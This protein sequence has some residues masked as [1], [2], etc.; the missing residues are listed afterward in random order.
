MISPEYRAVAT[1]I[2]VLSPNGIG[3]NAFW[4]ASLMGIS[5]IKQLTFIDPDP[6]PSKIAGEIR[7]F[8]P[9]DYLDF[10]LVKRTGRAVHLGMAAT[11]LALEDAGMQ[12]DDIDKEN[13]ELIFG[14]GC[15]SIDSIG[16]TYETYLKQG[17]DRVHP[18]SLFAGSIHM[19][20]STICNELG[21]KSSS[22]TLSTRCTAGLNAIGYALQMIRTGRV[23]T[24]ITGGFDAPITGLLFAAFCKSGLL[25][26]FQG[27]P[28]KASRPFDRLRDG[29]VL[30]EGAA[31]FVMEE[32]EYAIRNKRRIYGE[33]VGFG[34][35]GEHF[36]NNHSS[37]NGKGPHEGMALAIDKA[38]MDA[39]MLPEKIDYISAHAPSDLVLDKMETD[40]IK[41]AFGRHAYRLAI[42]SIKSTIGN[43]V[44]A[45][46][47]LQVASALLSLKDQ[48]IPPTINYEHPD[49]ECDLDYVPNEMR[50]NSIR[51]ILVNSHGFG[52]NCSAL[53]V[54]KFDG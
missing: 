22:T 34:N 2:G 23:K 13:T 33:I 45:A 32:M 24:V 47:P 30:S 38:L 44:A 16:N 36:N 10:K 46:A 7:D 52:G 18:F 5:G 1:G 6:F 54:K 40:A 48:R 31:V 25:T 42:S 51:N 26:T 14:V 21:L 37:T 41:A 29:G 11:K 12:K 17:P 9:T 50:Y 35:T 39:N 27:D 3:K 43:P 53:V 20:T 49:P 8:S 28:V 4:Q 15:P 19:P